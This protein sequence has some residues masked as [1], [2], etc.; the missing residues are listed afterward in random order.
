ME[1]LVG[2]LIGAFLSVIATAIFLPLIQDPVTD[3]L[4]T[5]LSNPFGTRS[6]SSLAGRW[7]Q[8]WQVDGRPGIKH[9]EPK[10]ELTQFGRSLA[11]KFTYD[12]RP[13]RLRARIEN[14]TFISGI[15]FDHAAGQ[16]YHGTF[17]AR[18]EID[19]KIV[20]GKW[21]G[22]SKSLSTFNTGTWKWTRD[23]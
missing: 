11:G 17:Q 10:L 12:G 3:F 1:Y 9:A 2:G 8:D 23:A 16:T 21:L 22:F 6:S 14:N 7:Q 19:Q 4:S 20:D 15:W 18:I 13:Y 5:R